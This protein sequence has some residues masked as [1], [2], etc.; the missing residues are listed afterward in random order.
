MNE[1]MFHLQAGDCLRLLRALREKPSYIGR[2]GE[3]AIQRSVRSMRHANVSAAIH[4]GTECRKVLQ[5]S[6]PKQSAFEL[7]YSRAMSAPARRQQSGLERRRDA[8]AAEGQL[9]GCALRALPC[10]GAGNGQSRRLRDGAST[11]DGRY[12]RLPADQNGSGRSSRPQSIKQRARKLVAISD[13]RRSQA[14]RS[15]PVRAWC[16]ESY[17]LA[18]TGVAC[19]SRGFRFIG[20]D[21][22]QHNLD[23]A[24][25]RILA[26]LGRS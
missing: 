1:P 10:L 12:V 2:H 25:A 16:G 8:E 9:Q 20:M 4:H 5:P 13:Q 11:S 3:Q 18:A 19:A 15:Q 7:W 17:F 14:R 6:L 26:S 23:I 24:R 22:E 21:L